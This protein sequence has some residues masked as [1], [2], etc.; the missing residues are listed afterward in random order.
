MGLPVSG[1]PVI[2]SI[3]G[4]DAVLVVTEPTVSGEH[5]MERV[6][7]LADFFNTPALVCV[8][9]ADLNMEKAGDIEKFALNRKLAFLGHIPF[10]PLFT[11]AMVQGQT[12]FEYDGNSKAANAVRA[13]WRLLSQ[14][15]A[16]S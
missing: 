9:K 11:R 3:G 1:C 12:I 16:H 2:A 8:N 15:L 7:R 4:A 10:D 14:S 6:I 13:I 5:D